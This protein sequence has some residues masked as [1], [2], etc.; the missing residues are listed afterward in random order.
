MGFIK[1][2]QQDGPPPLPHEVSTSPQRTRFMDEATRVAKG[3]TYSLIVAGLSHS[4]SSIAGAETILEIADK[5]LKGI[6]DR[7]YF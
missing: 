7:G 3:K 4:Y 1:T 2:S 6:E 5:L